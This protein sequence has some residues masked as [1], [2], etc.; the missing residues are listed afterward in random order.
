VSEGLTL[1]AALLLGLA[2]SGHCLVMCGGI[3]AALGIATAKRADGRPRTGLLVVYQAGRILSYTLAGLLFGGM[4]GGAIALLDIDAVRNGLRVLSAC[5]LLLGAF[6]AFGRVRDPGFGIGRRLWPKLAPLGRKLLPVDTLPRALGF[7]MLWG[8]MPCGFV[9]TVLIIA[10]LQLNALGGAM[11]MAA[12]GLGTAPALLISAYGAQRIAGFAARPATRHIA[13][14]VL[15]I[16]ALLT[17]A[18]PLLV[19]M[20][21]GL[22]GWL[23]FDCAAA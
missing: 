11:T 1:F 15:L 9:Y 19:Q 7:G 20:L 12:F 21:P 6:V 16:S 4:L 5:A 18:G 14:S 10:T 23:P 8:W 3:S 22:H 13:G 2:A 17:V